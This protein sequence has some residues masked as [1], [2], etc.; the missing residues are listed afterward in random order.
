MTVLCRGCDGTCCAV[1]THRSSAARCNLQGSCTS[2]RTA[3]LVRLFPPRCECQATFW[4][5]SSMERE[6]CPRLQVD[7]R[8]NQPHV[9]TAPRTNACHT[10]SQALPLM[11][12]PPRSPFGLRSVLQ[13]V[14]PTLLL[15]RFLAT[16][17]ESIGLIQPETCLPKCRLSSTQ[18]CR[19]SVAR[20]VQ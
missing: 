10:Q 2:G 12:E 20:S 16:S 8:P 3:P 6:R 11:T 9:A 15:R 5:E 14:C 13:P 7:R 18:S 19:R 4:T 1:S 17:K